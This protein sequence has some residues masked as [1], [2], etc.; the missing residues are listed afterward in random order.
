VAGD[1]RGSLNS[2]G[3]RAD[4]EHRAHGNPSWNTGVDY[5]RQLALSA[6][7]REVEALYRQADLDLGAD[8]TTL[9]QVPRIQ[10]DTGAIRYLSVQRLQATGGPGI[11]CQNPVGGGGSG[12]QRVEPGSSSEIEGFTQAETPQLPA[13]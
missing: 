8:L 7:R 9:A 6:D 12:R 1:G 2:F 3:F 5:G 4:L 10:A 11:R 13:L